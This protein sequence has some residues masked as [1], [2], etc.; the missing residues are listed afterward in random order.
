MFVTTTSRLFV[1]A[2]KALFSN[3]DSLIKICWA[4]YALLL[5]VQLSA[6]VF[7]GDMVGTGAVG[8]RDIVFTFVAVALFFVSSSSIAVAWHR[9]LLLEE[10][11]R[12]FHLKV[13]AREVTYLL[14]MLLVGVIAIVPAVIA[15]TLAGL[16]A[17]M[18]GRML[19][20]LS[21]FVFL[22]FFLPFLMRLSLILPAAAF[23][24]KLSIGEAFRD[25]EGLGFP[26]ALAAIGLGLIV[27]AV[28]AVLDYLTPAGGQ[29]MAAFA[30]VILSLV[31]QIV[32][33]ALQISVLTGGYYI[34][35]ERQ[36]NAAQQGQPPV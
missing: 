27:G 11:P 20:I 23:D 12:S 8:P 29:L 21:G 3:F 30:T 26:M 36:A 5:T 2:F 18:G 32:T 31:L 10:A 16:L 17:G 34:L 14:K 35:R 19:A 7:P 9:C 4:W 13:G 28:S 22:A 25:S 24:E 1:G 6:I 33:T 15:V